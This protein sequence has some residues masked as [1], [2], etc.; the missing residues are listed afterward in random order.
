LYSGF[1]IDT[2][3]QDLHNGYYRQFF[4]NGCYAGVAPVGDAWLKAITTNVARRN[5]Y[6]PDPSKVNLAP[7]AT[8]LLPC[9]AASRA[10]V[11]AQWCS[12]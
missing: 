1:P 2:V 3:T 11:A 4:A 12:W 5:P 10:A 9:C 6:A 8:R 7:S